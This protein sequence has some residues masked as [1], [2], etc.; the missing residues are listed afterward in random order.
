[1]P[2]LIPLTVVVQVLSARPLL[3]IEE[4]RGGGARLRR[5]LVPNHSR[6]SSCKQQQEMMMGWGS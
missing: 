2:Y 5:T 1:M 4:V 3:R 6:R